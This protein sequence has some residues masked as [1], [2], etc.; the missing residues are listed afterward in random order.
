MNNNSINKIEK[1]N[2]FPNL[3]NDQ[4]LGEYKKTLEIM[5]S[6]KD[7]NKKISFSEIDKH[8]KLSRELGSRKVDVKQLIPKQDHSQV[9]AKYPPIYSERDATAIKG[10]STHLIESTFPK[11]DEFKKV[12]KYLEQENSSDAA[13]KE[14]MQ[15]RINKQNLV[16][17]DGTKEINNAYAYDGYTYNKKP[18]KNTLIKNEQTQMSTENQ[19]KNT[20][21]NI[22]N[23]STKAD[24]LDSEVPIDNSTENRLLE[25]AE[26]I[27]T[28]RA[29]RNIDRIDEE[30]QRVSDKI[31]TSKE[32]SRENYKLI[33]RKNG[34]ESRR[35]IS[36]SIL[37]QEKE[38]ESRIVDEMTHDSPDTELVGDL[39]KINDGLEK[40]AE[41]V[42]S[43]DEE[44]AAE[45]DKEFAGQYTAQPVIKDLTDEHHSPVE[46]LTE[47]SD[48]S[49]EG[50]NPKE[51]ENISEP[52][53]T[54][55]Q[56][57]ARFLNNLD[58]GENEKKPK[59]KPKSINILEQKLSEQEK[60][61][62]VTKKLGMLGR[63][64][65]R[66]KEGKNGKTWYGKYVEWQ[67][68]GSKTM[69]FAKK[70]IIPGAAALLVSGGSLFA[71]GA[72]IFAAGTRIAALAGAGAVSKS[73]YESATKNRV[74]RDIDS[75][76]DLYKQGKNEY[77]SELTDEGVRLNRQELM[78]MRELNV[79]Y[80]KDTTN[81][82]QELLDLES[83]YL[84]YESQ[85]K[86]KF[87]E[88]K[89]NYGELIHRRKLKNERVAAMVAAIPAAAY[90]GYNLTNLMGNLDFSGPSNEI[91]VA[92][93][94]KKT[95][96]LPKK[97]ESSIS[98]DAFVNKGE[99]I[100]HALKRQLESNPA[101]A[102]KLN[103][104]GKVSDLARIA[105]DFGYIKSDGSD[106]RVLMGSGAA[107]E[108]TLD[109]AGNPMVREHM[110]GHVE[111][112]KYV[113]GTFTES[114]QKG[115]GFEGS[116][117]EKKYEYIH[118]VNNQSSEYSG[119]KLPSS[120]NIQT[121]GIDN[122]INGNLN[123]SLVFQK[124]PNSIGGISMQVDGRFGPAFNNI[125]TDR[126]TLELFHSKG[127]TLD[128]STMIELGYRP[129]ENGKFTNI[130]TG[131][132]LYSWKDI[133]E[134]TD[135]ENLKSQRP[136]LFNNQRFNGNGDDTWA[137]D[138]NSGGVDPNNAD[139]I[140]NT[141]PEKESFTQTTGHFKVHHDEQGGISIMSDADF[142]FKGEIERGEFK[143]REI[144]LIEK[145]KYTS[146][147]GIPIRADSNVPELQ[148]T[149]VV[150]LKN[151]Q[152]AFAALAGTG[153][154]ASG[155]SIAAKR[156]ELAMKKLGMPN[157]SEYA[158]S[159]GKMSPTSYAARSFTPIS[160]EQA[161]Y[162][163]KI[164]S[165]IN[166]YTG[167]NNPR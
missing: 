52:K 10:L 61:S 62:P 131:D 116:G 3:S 100:T 128:E 9:K 37:D 156:L 98:H 32:G 134:Q 129:G 149:A 153:N 163:G 123:Q 139:F 60:Q 104:N 162:I 74:Q 20:T 115:S 39:K 94:S 166:R 65:S 18:K 107:Y 143:N 159:M 86:T 120:D 118:T 42:G 87:S 125:V 140:E 93:I 78:R 8:N 21:Q 31:N 70:L 111:G 97:I 147:E 80:K 54:I 73:I 85:R 12:R 150:K 121:E 27:T 137:I 126:Y 161:R 22:N 81:K 43:S 45:L 5:K 34:L 83:R 165:E 17:Y 23:L 35:A 127:I 157:H 50:K 24:V 151:G 71:A 91:D 30:L 46:S 72:G 15:Q 38:N 154:E 57:N 155:P 77:K 95:P 49:H 84:S 69:K 136:E 6:A 41:N 48:D 106:V 33:A 28:Q 146:I 59:L 133:Y 88:A 167:K 58:E 68:K 96:D 7:Q 16:S 117:I 56:V 144:N 11:N 63:H 141:S 55:E 160:E 138:N 47:G 40:V 26:K 82:P 124:Y 122:K 14:R 108:L 90:G 142:K 89:T 53:E 29:Q 64:L 101:I 99:G 112:S 51:T 164:Y 145:N 92:E 66:L 76:K 36:Q 135:F 152:Y 105:K 110:N 114:H 67:N 130:N 158:V 113:D 4:L 19:Q 2:Q 13:A 109:E 75:Y 79:L 148:G 1:P 103:Y 132:E 102:E 25:K 44:I 119:V